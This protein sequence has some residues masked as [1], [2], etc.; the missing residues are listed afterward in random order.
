MC[1]YGRNEFK[2]A[3]SKFQY[4][5]QHILRGNIAPAGLSLN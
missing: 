1:C 3:T 4:Q 5:T 2:A